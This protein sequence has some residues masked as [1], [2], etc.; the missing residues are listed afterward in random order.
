MFRQALL[1]TDRTGRESNPAREH[2]AVGAAAVS[3]PVEDDH[4]AAH[5]FF[6]AGNRLEELAPMEDES[7]AF[8]W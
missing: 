7:R 2:R 3:P 5:L 4:V 6:L 1:R 8:E